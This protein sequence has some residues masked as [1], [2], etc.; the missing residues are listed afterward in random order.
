MGGAGLG[1][2][3]VTRVALCIL[4]CAAAAAAGSAT[5]APGFGVAVYDSPLSVGEENSLRSQLRA[6]QTAYAAAVSPERR[7]KVFSNRWID[8]AMLDGAEPPLCDLEAVVSRLWQRVVAPGLET[9]G[10]VAGASPDEIVGAEWWLQWRSEREGMHWHVDRDEAAREAARSGKRGVPKNRPGRYDEHGW[11][12][13]VLSTVWYAGETG[14]CTA[15]LHQAMLPHWARAKF[16]PELPAE[17]T[18]SCPQLGRYLVFD[19]A[20]PRKSWRSVAL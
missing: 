19:G 5:G 2:A 1:C 10:S 7:A 3:T 6:L 16:D 4:S 9:R 15:V 13:P 20:Y 8:R 17:A 18:L 11:A 12:H 14:G